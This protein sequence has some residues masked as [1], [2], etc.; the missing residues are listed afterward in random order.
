MHSQ[1][2]TPDVCRQDMKFTT[3]HGFLV[4]LGWV[5]QQLGIGDALDRHMRIQ[6]KVVRHKPV[7]KVI[8][9]L[10]GI[11]GDC[12][13]MKDL[14]L[15]PEPIVTDQSVA[16]AWGQEKF[17]HSSTVCAT[18]GKLTPEN[19]E[20]LSYALAEIQAPLLR[21]EVEALAG[22]DRQGLV[23]VDIDLT[24]QKVRGE[25]KQYTGTDFGYIQ[26]KLARGYQI[27]AAFLSG[28]SNRFAIAGRLKSGKANAQSHRCLLELLPTRSKPGLAARAAGWNGS[29]SASGSTS[30]AWVSCKTS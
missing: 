4:T 1:G 7:D 25:A 12:R 3:R 30:C 10:V 17:A 8:E 2:T 27:V 24:G 29:N 9:A 16:R 11:L 15:A 20:Q 18:F 13:Y 5:A 26:G 19:V 21:Q 6:Q 23:V 14:N 28:R 22:P